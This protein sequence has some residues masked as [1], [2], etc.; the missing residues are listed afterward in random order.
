MSISALRHQ[1]F[2]RV[3]N[4]TTHLYCVACKTG[5]KKC[6]THSSPQSDCMEAPLWNKGASKIGKSHLLSSLSVMSL[7]KGLKTSKKN[8]ASEDM[9]R[10]FFTGINNSPHN[11][12]HNCL[13]TSLH[14]NL[15]NC[16]TVCYDVESKI[17]TKSIKNLL[18]YEQFNKT[19]N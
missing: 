15:H 7:Q 11:S 10:P 6:Y 19:R 2:N 5:Y 14:N 8:L 13:H 17:W 1:L 16:H 4:L 12:L 18:R 3:Y 9:D